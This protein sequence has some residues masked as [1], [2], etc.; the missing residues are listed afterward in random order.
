MDFFQFKSPTKI[1]FNPGISKDFGSELDLIP[2]QKYFIITDKIISDLKLI[3]PIVE[4]IQNTGREVVGIFT[5]V[6]PDSGVKV[7]EKCASLAKESGAEGFIAVGGGSVMDTAK[8]VNLLFT[9]G[10]NLKEDYSGSQ[11]IP[12]DLSPLIAIPT[13]AGTGSEVTEV[14][15][16]YD[17]ET[18]TKLGFADVHL[19]PTMTLLD[20]ELT[21]GLPP[22][23]TAATGLDALTHAIESVMSVQKA[24]IPYA[25]ATQAISLIFKNLVAAVEDGSDIEARGGMLVA[26]T[27]AGMAFNHSM[28]GVVHCVA[29]TIGAM[30]HVHHGT[31]NGIFLAEGMRYNLDCRES[32]I[33]SLAPFM[34]V[35][36]Q[37]S[38]RAI[39]EACIVRVEALVQ[40]LNKVCGFPMRYRDIGIPQEALEKIAEKAP[41]DGSSFYNPREVVAADLLPF[42]EKAW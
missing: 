13:T 16:I 6:P 29:H 26:S 32:E 35:V 1:V 30:Y 42:L 25:L 27:M 7:I 41:E 18:Q 39:A 21:T 9:L 38:E 10:G 33:A 4:G 23:I 40:E 37:G 3:D 19:L 5:D 15:V 20:P 2:I 17:D 11:T 24:P 12:Q 36:P 8:G 28:V 34:G 31:A 22:K 14:M